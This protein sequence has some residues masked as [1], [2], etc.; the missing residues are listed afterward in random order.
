MAQLYLPFPFQEPP[1]L[2]TDGTG[3]ISHVPFSDQRN[4]PDSLGRIRHRSCRP[5]GLSV[6]AGVFRRYRQV[7]HNLQYVTATDCISIDHGNYRFDKRTYGLVNLKHIQSRSTVRVAISAS[8]FVML[9]T[10]ATESFVSGSGESTTTRAP[11]GIATIVQRVGN[12]VIGPARP[13]RIIYFGAVDC[14]LCDS[15][16]KIE[17]DIG[18][19]MIVFQLRI[20]LL[21]YY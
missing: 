20:F 15:F 7:T 5:W 2:C 6:E 9:V 3:T 17:K 1:L 14:Y 18:I 11:R 10:T 21:L 8:R 13:E 16:I 4:V 19:F 12:L